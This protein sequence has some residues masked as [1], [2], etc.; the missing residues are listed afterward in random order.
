[1]TK[2]DYG[3]EDIVAAL[4]A[5]NVQAGDS[6]FTH[7]NIGFFGKP[8]DATT[9]EQTYELFKK[10]VFNVI[11]TGGT[12]ISPAFSYNFF[13]KEA[14]DPK[15]SPSTMGLLSEMMR[16]DPEAVRSRDPNFSVVAV[17]KNADFFVHDTPAHSFGKDSFWDRFLQKNGKICNFNFDAGSTFLHYVEKMLAVPYRYDKAFNGLIVRDGKRE[18][19]TVYHFVHSLEIPGDVAD[20]RAFDKAAKTSGIAK[21]ADLGKGQIVVLSARDAFNLVKDE[22]RD[23]PHF[24]R[25]S[26]HVVV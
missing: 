20:F 4:E 1:M 6:L 21:T 13:M 24:L 26:G 5:C 25:V 14:Y 15:N 16:I 7:S 3:C 22:L 9:A 18:R 12:W 10:A 11:D 17:G 19:K 2:S 23:N 8:S